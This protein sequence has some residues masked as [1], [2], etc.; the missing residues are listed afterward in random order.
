MSQ[1][2]IDRLKEELGG[3]KYTKDDKFLKLID[4]VYYEKCIF[5]EEEDFKS[6][7]FN[8][9]FDNGEVIQLDEWELVIL[10]LILSDLKKCKNNETIKKE[11]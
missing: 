11:I 10:A 2:N 7:G 3:V 4:L 1:E 9:Y 8:W 5:Q 6:G